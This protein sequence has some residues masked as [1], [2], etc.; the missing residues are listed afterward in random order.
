MGRVSGSNGA[1]THTQGDH[2]VWANT[3]RPALLLPEDAVTLTNFDI[4]FPDFAK[5]D[6]YG[7]TFATAN[8]FDYS[9]C[10]S[11][12]SLDPQEWDSG[13]S[14]VCNLPAGS[15]Y[16]E[17]ELT[18]SRIVAPSSVMGVDGPIPALLGGGGKHM[19]DGNSALIEGVG[20]LVRMFA[21]ERVGN[22][23][24]LRRKQSVANEGQRVPW[25][26]GN[27]NST[28]SGG[29]RSGFTY[30]GNPSAWPV[31]QIDQRTGGNID[32]RRGGPNAC[33]LSDPTNYAS[34]W[35][36]TAVITPGYIKI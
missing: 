21:F 8:G 32:K 13:L 1:I 3:R 28:G 26:S 11:W 9:A 31:H 7:F 35:R 27:N 23:V 10:V 24:Y 14:F 22:A 36:G 5:S 6:A 16:F 25:N 18:L 12:V 2:V 20:P 15:N 19:P 34:L 29:Y 33:S 17:V 4:A 30:G